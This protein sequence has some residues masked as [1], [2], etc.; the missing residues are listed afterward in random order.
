MK[1]SLEELAMRLVP[2][3]IEHL[4]RK[5]GRNADL[6]HE[7]TTSLRKIFTMVSDEFDDDTLFVKALQKGV[8]P[9]EIQLEEWLDK[10]L[11]PIEC[12]ATTLKGPISKDDY[13]HA[14]IVYEALKRCGKPTFKDYHE[15]YLKVDVLLLAEVSALDIRP[16]VSLQLCD[17][18]ELR[19]SGHVKSN[20]AKGRRKTPRDSP[21]TKQ[22]NLRH[23][24]DGQNRWDVCCEY[25]QN[26]CQ[27][28]RYGW[29]RSNEGAVLNY[30]CGRVFSVSLCTNQASNAWI[31]FQSR[32]KS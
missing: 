32:R 7:Q 23:L 19:L 5:R 11:P 27:Y 21:Y 9:Y 2:D 18:L 4:W 10:E 30:I 20:S 6:T 17:R 1:S 28:S 16:D 15:Y 26:R 12:F 13:E 22:R 14:Q 24:L 31:P 29:V 25:C 3:D 8:Y